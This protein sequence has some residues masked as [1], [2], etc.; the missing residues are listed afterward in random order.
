[1]Q[2]RLEAG[3]VATTTGRLHPSGPRPHARPHRNPAVDYNRPPQYRYRPRSIYHVSEGDQPYY[4]EDDAGP[5]GI[6]SDRDREGR[7]AHTDAHGLR[8]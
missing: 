6:R 1:M 8:A 2:L 5:S 3:E 4:G 7:Y